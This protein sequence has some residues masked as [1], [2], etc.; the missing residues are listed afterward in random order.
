[1]RNDKKQAHDKKQTR[2]GDN[3]LFFDFARVASS[4]H[5]ATFNMER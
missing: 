5:A 1:M 3:K 2:D 4:N